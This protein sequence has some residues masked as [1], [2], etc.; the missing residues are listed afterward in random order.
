MQKAA[1]CEGKYGC[2]AGDL[3]CNAKTGGLNPTAYHHHK[4][5]G[6]EHWCVRIGQ[7]KKNSAKKDK[8]K[9]IFSCS[10]NHGGRWKTEAEADKGIRSFRELLEFG[11]TENVKTLRGSEVRWSD[12]AEARRVEMQLRLKR[13]EGMSQRDRRQ[14]KF[15]LERDRA[16]LNP[17]AVSKRSCPE[18]PA[19]A[20]PPPKRVPKKAP[21]HD[22]KLT[23]AYVGW[24]VRIMKHLQKY[25]D[26]HNCWKLLDEVLPAALPSS[27]SSHNISLATRKATAVH[28]YCETYNRTYDPKSFAFG[29]NAEACSDFAGAFSGG[30]TGRTIF[31]Y[32]EE[33]ELSLGRRGDDF[34][35]ATNSGEGT[36][37]L[38]HRGKY[39]RDW[40]LTEEDYLIKFEQQMSNNL[41]QLSV[42]FMTTWVN[43]TLL[44]DLPIEVSDQYGVNRPIRRNTVH[45]WMRRAGAKNEVYQKSY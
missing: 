24:R 4:G 16:V 39:E 12:Q 22:E 17:P 44:I 42:D 21:V 10:H 6:D 3:W 41:A 9:W 2:R 8:G 7:K 38:D 11:E 40:L 20:P 15:E 43:E 28:S 5:R 45:E 13:E 34:D 27:I 1:C 19:T 29:W 32:W 26:S 36:F 35:P 23:A 31:N 33:Y 37:K 14:L 18:T 25:L 30:S